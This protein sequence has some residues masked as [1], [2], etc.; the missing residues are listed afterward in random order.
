MAPHEPQQ[1][2]EPPQQQPPPPLEVEDIGELLMA[3]L[4]AGGRKRGLDADWSSPCSPPSSLAAGT[5]RKGGS[6]PRRRSAGGRLQQTA[7]TSATSTTTKTPPRAAGPHNEAD[8]DGEGDDEEED[9]VVESFWESPVVVSVVQELLAWPLGLAYSAVVLVV[10]TWAHLTNLAV[11]RLNKFVRRLGRLWR[12]LWPYLARSSSSDSDCSSVPCPLKL[13]DRLARN[14]SMQVIK[15]G[16][17]WCGPNNTMVKDA[18]VGGDSPGA[19]TDFFVP[20]RPSVIYVHGYQ[21]RWVGLVWVATNT[22]LLMLGVEVNWRVL[23]I[24]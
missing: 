21:P 2:E 16:L 22:E 17:Y 12:C 7:A 5:P 23:I 13:P 6:S 15:S 8:D 19:A 1:Q 4:L 24:G 20:G 18:S 9:A 14:A 11:Y 3:R 10:C